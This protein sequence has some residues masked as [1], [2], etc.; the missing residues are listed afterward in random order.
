MSTEQNGSMAGTPSP[1]WLGS[2]DNRCCGNCLWW[3]TFV[4]NDDD[5]EC[6]ESGVSC[7]RWRHEKCD[8]WGNR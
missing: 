1:A 3:S 7:M 8:K 6:I 2:Q 5:G 4:G